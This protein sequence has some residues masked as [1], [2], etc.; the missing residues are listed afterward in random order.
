M[1]Q[2]GFT[3]IELLGVLIILGL[4]ALIAFPVV[5]KAIKSGREDMYQ[6]QID[7]I[8]VS[9]KAWASNNMMNLPDTDG[10][11][12]TVTLD[13]LKLSGYAELEVKNPK[14]ETLFPGDMLIRIKRSKNAYLY[15]VDETSGTSTKAKEYDLHTPTIELN[16]S[17]MIYVSIGGTYTEL[18]AIGKDE[19]S[20]NLS[21]GNPSI[22]KNGTQYSTI[23]TSTAGTYN[24][25]YT[26]YHNG[27]SSTIIR[28][29]IVK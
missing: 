4:L 10:E 7:S 16:G 5:N 6:I 14:T 2:K 12:M 25:Y 23:D 19:N 13:Q 18:G 3:L 9:A 22:Y 20:G 28:T 1:K 15:E 11:V 27:L 29:V 21:V 26:V 17:P 24:L 8:L